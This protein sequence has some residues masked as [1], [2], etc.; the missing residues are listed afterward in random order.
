MYLY[1]DGV[2]EAMGEESNQ[3]TM[4]RMLETIELGQSLF[5]QMG[6]S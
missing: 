5:I 6:E 4:K 2:P 1:S 3:F